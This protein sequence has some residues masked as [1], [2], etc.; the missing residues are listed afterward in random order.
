MR[1]YTDSSFID[2]IEYHENT[3]TLRINM[4]GKTYAYQCGPT[5]YA[6]FLKAKSF[7][8]FYNQRIKP[9]MKGVLETA[10]EFIT[11]K[12]YRTGKYRFNHTSGL[13]KVF[14]APNHLWYGAALVEDDD[15]AYTHGCAHQNVAMRTID[16]LLLD[17]LRW[18]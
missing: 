16:K 11:P 10:K 4:N 1:T 3:Y 2:W 14:Y 8:R 13:G 6:A 5:L 9:Y 17:I 15:V 18:T 12:W 7:G